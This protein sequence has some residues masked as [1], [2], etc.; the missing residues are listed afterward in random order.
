MPVVG[1]TYRMNPQQARQAEGRA[2]AVSPDSVG[3]ESARL[4]R[5]GARKPAK[6]GVPTVLL[7]RHGQTRLNSEHGERLRGWLDLPL[8]RRGREDAAEAGEKLK[9][10]DVAALFSSDLRRARQTARIIGEKIG[11]KPTE[12]PKL[13]PWNVGDLA[14]KLVADVRE[15][16]DYYQ[17]H[18][19][20]KTPGGES[21]ESFYERW[22]Q[23]LLALLRKAEKLPPGQ[24]VVALTHVRNLLTAPHILAGKPGPTESAR[25]EIRVIG[26]PHP[27]TGELVAI[28][29]Q[30]GKWV[31]DKSGFSPPRLPCQH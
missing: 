30:N 23:E 7:V 14:G 19:D 29:K 21:F 16:M 10:Y 1:K 13:R 11:V 4:R 5:G 6:A 8:T 15:E 28:T 3:E 31:M 9:D 12:N 26:R 18:P 17:K 24:V 22:E 25:G 2:D 27:G 20:K